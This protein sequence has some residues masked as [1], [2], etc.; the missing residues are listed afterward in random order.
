MK[1]FI[2]SSHTQSP[3]RV[4]NIESNRPADKHYSTTY[5]MQFIFLRHPTGTP[6]S[7]LLHVSS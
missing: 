3:L 1:A 7:V 4:S 2:H 6:I 5:T